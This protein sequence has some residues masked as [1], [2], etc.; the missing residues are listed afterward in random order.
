MTTVFCAPAEEQRQ[1]SSNVAAKKKSS[2]T[3]PSADA[4]QPGFEVAMKE[5]QAIVE[6]MEDGDQ[7]L[8]DSVKDFERGMELKK[9]CE[10]TLRT[11]EAR[12]DKLVKKAGGYTEEEFEPDE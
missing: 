8:E 3:T 12:I 10:D 11:A 6:R 7:S 9:I 4:E 5:L 2:K 1:E